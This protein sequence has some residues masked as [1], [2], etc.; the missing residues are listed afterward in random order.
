MV[1]PDDPSFVVCD[2]C[3]D[4]GHRRKFCDGTRDVLCGRKR[5]HLPHDFVEPCTCRSSNRRYLEKRFG[6]VRVA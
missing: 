4:T 2:L 6:A 3:D 5:A 1:T